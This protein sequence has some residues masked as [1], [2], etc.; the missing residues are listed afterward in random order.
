MIPITVGKGR[1][2]N[3]F[4]ICLLESEHIEVEG[5]Q[6]SIVLAPG[7]GFVED[8]FSVDRGEEGGFQMTQA[9]C[10]S[11]VLYFSQQHITSAPPQI[12]WR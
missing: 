1:N 8:N 5:E 4:L 2:L 6:F 12:I 10:T 7:I 11:C 9:P 3:V